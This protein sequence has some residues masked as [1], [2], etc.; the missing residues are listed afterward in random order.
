VPGFF[1][2]GVAGGGVAAGVGHGGSGIEYAAGAGAGLTQ[3]SLKLT[4]APTSS[5]PLYGLATWIWMGAGRAVPTTAVCATASVRAATIEQA[6]RTSR[7][8]GFRLELP[9]ATV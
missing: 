9:L 3:P 8:F 4:V 5:C 7:L 2:D 6:V 1:G